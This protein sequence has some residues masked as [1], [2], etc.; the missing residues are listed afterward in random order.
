ML[1][2]VT[3]CRAKVDDQRGWGRIA[4]RADVS[5]HGRDASP[6]YRGGLGEVDVVQMQAI[7]IDQ[8]LPMFRPSLL[9]SL[10]QFG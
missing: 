2:D 8:L 3:A 4:E 5:H 7:R 6:S 9:L 1:F 10:G